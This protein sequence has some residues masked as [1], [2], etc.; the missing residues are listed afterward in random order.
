M[1]ITATH[2]KNNFGEVMELARKGPVTVS[3]SGKPAVAIL[4][5]DEYARLRRIE[6]QYWGDVANRAKESGMLGTDGTAALLADLLKPD[7]D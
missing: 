1:N 3:K 4:D 5:I 2:V 7:V 6:N